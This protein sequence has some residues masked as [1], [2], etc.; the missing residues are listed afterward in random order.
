MIKYLAP[1]IVIALVG[2]ASQPEKLYQPAD[3]KN[4][5][6][7]CSNAHNQ[8]DYLNL[9]VDEYHEYHKT[10][11]I[12]LEDRRYYGLLKNKIWGLRATCDAR[13]L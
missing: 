1:A 8:L 13:S 9:K 2:C 10:H 6:A 12:T 11:P 7:S 4:F 3:M 5:A